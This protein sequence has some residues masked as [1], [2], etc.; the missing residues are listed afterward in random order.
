MGIKKTRNTPSFIMTYFSGTDADGLRK[1]KFP[2]S[3][4][5]PCVNQT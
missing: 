1:A 3:A 5:D 4:L 2:G